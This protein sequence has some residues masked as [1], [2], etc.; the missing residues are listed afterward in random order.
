MQDILLEM[1]KNAIND[2]V[3]TDTQEEL[4]KYNAVQSA[5]NA[6]FEALNL[7]WCSTHILRYTF[8]TMVLMGTKSLSAVQATLGYTELDRP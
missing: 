5:F 2:L 8:T 7:S 3:F 6:G 4:L 1:K